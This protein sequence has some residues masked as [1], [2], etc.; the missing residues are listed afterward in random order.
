[1][2]TRRV[3]GRTALT[4][5]LYADFRCR[6]ARFTW[7]EERGSIVAPMDIVYVG[8]IL[9]LFALVGLMAV[10]VDRL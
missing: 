1:M 5:N 3:Y 2:F 7:G 6:S 8:L 4:G 10:G 9:V